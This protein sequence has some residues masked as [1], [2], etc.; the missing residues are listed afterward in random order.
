[1]RKQGREAEAAALIAPLHD[2]FTEGLTTTDLVR[3]KVLLDRP[4]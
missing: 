3:A 4:M 2:R 1:M